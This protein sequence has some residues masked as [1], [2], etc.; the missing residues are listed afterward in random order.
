MISITGSEIAI[1]G[2][3][4]DI[5]GAIILVGF[6][7]K[8]YLHSLFSKEVKKEIEDEAIAVTTNRMAGEREKMLRD[9]YTRG[10]ISAYK[11]SFWGFL[12]LTIG[13]ILQAIG[14][15]FGSNVIFVL[16]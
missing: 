13:F 3:F 8:K 14:T 1:L 11:N 16:P 2:L 5:L 9:P 12:L 6:S 15:W 7:V 10:F 4:L